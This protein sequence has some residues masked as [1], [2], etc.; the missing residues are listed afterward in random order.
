MLARGVRSATKAAGH[1]QLPQLSAAIRE[2]FCDKLEK[3]PAPPPP[4]RNSNKKNN[5]REQH[6]A[7]MS[8]TASRAS[9]SS[10]SDGT[11]VESGAVER[12]P[13]GVR[14]RVRVT[15]GAKASAVTQLTATEVCIRLAAA[16]HDNL[17]NTELV[18]FLSREVFRVPKSSVS[19]IRGDTSR[20]KVVAVADLTVQSAVAQLLAAIDK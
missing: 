5:T 6:I 7:S 9:S 14:I 18:R 20:N 17:A 13:T 2:S 4:H 3:S 16:A 11:V 1:P 19:L 12:A 8:S 10:S 15:P